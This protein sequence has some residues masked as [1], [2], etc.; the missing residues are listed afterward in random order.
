M[1]SDSHKD[2]DITIDY[3]PDSGLG[4]DFYSSGSSHIILVSI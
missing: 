4:E 3:Y 2:K 1:Y